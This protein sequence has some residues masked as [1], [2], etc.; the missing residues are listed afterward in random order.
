MKKTV[1]GILS[2]MLAF[3]LLFAMLLPTYAA[4]SNEAETKALALKQIGLFRG[5]SDT[6]L[7]LDRAPTRTEALV[8]LIR[9]MGKESEALGGSWTHPFT[10]VDSWADKYVGCGYEMGLTKGVSATE[11]GTGTADSDMYLTFMLRALGYSDTAGDFAWNAPDALAKAVGILPN[12]VDV[13]NF[14]R[15]DVAI[16]SWAALEADLKTGMQRLA[17]KLIAENV[18]TGDAYAQAVAL[19][20]ETS[21]TEK[22]V[23]SL[24][25]LKSA[26]SDSSV[27]VI[28]IDSIGTPLVITGAV[29]IPAGVTVTVNRGNDFYIEG[30]L[31]NNGTINVLGADSVSTDFINYSVMTVQAGGTLDNN[32]AINLEAAPLEDEDDYGPVGGQLRLN[33]GTLNNKGSV[34]LKYGL[35]NTHGGM[36]VVIDGTF[37]NDGLVI[38]D[39]FFLRVDNG[40]FVNNTGAVV[41]NNTNFFTGGEGIF[42]NNGTL[43]GAAVSKES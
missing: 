41:I 33:G 5:V 12:S 42:T 20:D 9:A 36:A 24:E 37:N 18:F 1:K 17:K 4:N 31:T 40:S 35:T 15:A 27:K 10:D 30:T 32:G 22:S 16:V 39:G 23:S 3:T 43:S 29:T 11:F 14:L 13:S 8:M 6:D 21:P 26:L 7:A 2:L 34:F 28:T 19:V 38:V 25:S